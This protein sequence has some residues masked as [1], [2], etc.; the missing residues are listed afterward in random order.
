MD[1]NLIK[2]LRNVAEVLPDVASTLEN[3]NNKE[4]E[5][6]LLSFLGRAMVLLDEV[7]FI[8]K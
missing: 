6:R 5:I 1:S 8:K 4:L 7:G 2:S 3:I